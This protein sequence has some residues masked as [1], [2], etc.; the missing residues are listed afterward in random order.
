MNTEPSRILGLTTDAWSAIGIWVTVGVYLAIGFVAWRQLREA[1]TLRREQTRPFIVVELHAR[2]IL[3]SLLIRNAG[4]T[5]ARQIVVRLDQPITSSF[6]PS[7]TL[8][9]QHKGIF[10]DGM[11]AMAP[12]E[13]LRFILD[14][15]PARVGARLP[16]TI[17]GNVA[18]TDVLG[19]RYDDR[20]AIDLEIYSNSSIPDLDLHDLVKEVEKLR[21]D[22]GRWSTKGIVANTVDKRRE[23]QRGV[24]DWRKRRVQQ[25]ANTEGRIAAARYLIGAT[26]RRSQ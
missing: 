15:F 7:E 10:G 9:W 5:Q 24:R 13:Q 25:I 18:Y 3:L 1:K 16:M 23:E 14:S 20:F 22:L 12:G 4:V 11:P 17:S 19:H 2:S 6:T 21:E 8:A 26:L